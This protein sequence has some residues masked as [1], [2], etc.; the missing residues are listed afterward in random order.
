MFM[1]NNELDR[2]VIETSSDTDDTY[3]DLNGE[4]SLSYQNVGLLFYY[5]NASGYSGNIVDITVQ[6][7]MDGVGYY[8]NG[9]P[10]VNIEVNTPFSDPG[11]T[12]VGE[13]TEEYSYQVT[14]PVD[15]SVIGEYDLEYTV[16]D[17]Q[18]NEIGTIVR[19][20]YVNDFTPP[21]VE[22][23]GPETVY[24]E[25]NGFFID[26]GV[27]Y[28]DNAQIIDQVTVEQN[29]DFNTIGEYLISY[30]VSDM[31]GNTTTITR[32][33]IVQDTT[34]PAFTFLP[35]VD[36]VLQGE[37]WVDAGYEVSDN[38]TA[39]EDLQITEEGNVDTSIL[40][41]YD[42]TYQVEDELGNKT[43]MVRTIY[44]VEPIVTTIPLSCDSQNSQ[45]MVNTILSIPKCYLNEALLTD[46]D[47]SNVNMNMPGV[48]PIYF[49]YVYND[50]SYQYRT[51]IIVVSGNDMILP[52]ATP[53]EIKED[54][55]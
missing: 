21:V 55:S 46:Y 11:I 50:V 16:Y 20:V 49:N 39:F 35:G 52:I 26:D 4:S 5:W 38:Y 12:I 6:S 15:T 30:T 43:T 1:M 9:Y 40:G 53:Y 48:Y 33:I 47:S 7:S 32:T 13:N 28:S 51:F 24:M 8:M 3:R 2:V 29:V 34:A 23:L 41:A 44:V 22:L 42:I 17:N 27:T 19:T 45:V 25:V 14:N 54:E 10:E 37:A 18:L 31:A 36:T